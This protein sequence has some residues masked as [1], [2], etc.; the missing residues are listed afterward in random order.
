MPFKI[1]M[2][3]KNNFYAAVVG[4]ANIDIS[5]KAYDNFIS[6]DS[7]PGKVSF[8]FGGVGRNI[9]ENLARLNIPV[10]FINVFSDDLYGDQIKESCTQNGIDISQ[11]QTVAGSCASVY[12]SIADNYGEMKSAIADMSIYDKLTPEFLQKKLPVINAA[13]VCITDTNIPQQ[14][15]EF[16]LKNCTVPVFVDPVSVAKAAKIQ[17]LLL[18][19]H[20]LKPN[21]HEAEFLSG[22]KIKNKKDV[23]CAAETLLKKGVKRVF[24]SLGQKGLFCADGKND[25]F[26]PSNPVRAVHTSGA[27]DSM[28][29]ALAWSFMHGLSLE[30]SAKAANA[31]ASICIESEKTV[32]EQMSAALLCTR[33]QLQISA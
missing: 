7:N 26:I 25:F 15:L 28:A 1:N 24:V 9:A 31:A 23:Q 30:E 5:A 12:V 21:K 13:S 11:S 17:N 27:G 10:H 2:Q 14:S 20:T 22:I 19:I 29:A 3:V 18:Y 16:L 6:A 33:A 4:A 32:S 8:S